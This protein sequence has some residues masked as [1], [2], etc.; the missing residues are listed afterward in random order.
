MTIRITVAC[1]DTLR[2]DVNQFA[3]VMAHGPADANTYGDPGWQDADG[4]LYT[5]ASF[6]APDEW[7]TAAQSP[8]QRPDWDDPENPVV[9]MDA[10]QR[11]QA[12]I[13][14]STDAISATPTAITAIGGVDGI[15][16][17]KAMG[18]ERASSD[19]EMP[20]DETPV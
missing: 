18:L 11:A 15:E 12:A 10:A 9:D 19:E 8:L 20:L 16:A 3:M 5:A 17:L 13:V 4:N 2:D 7:I 14:Y 6:V 1:P